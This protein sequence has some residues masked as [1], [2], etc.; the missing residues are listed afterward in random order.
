[1]DGWSFLGLEV[2]GDKKHLNQNPKCGKCINFVADG[3]SKKQ[4]LACSPALVRKAGWGAGGGVIWK[5]GGNHKHLDL[6][7]ALMSCAKQPVLTDEP[8]NP[9]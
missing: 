4:K 9:G 5:G 6:Q 2:K 1:M 8:V 3:K 7:M